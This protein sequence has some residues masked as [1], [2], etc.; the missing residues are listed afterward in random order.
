M[1]VCLRPPIGASG[2]VA[3][4]T[5]I[6]PKVMMDLLRHQSH[7]TFDTLVRRK[8]QMKASHQ[9]CTCGGLQGMQIILVFAHAHALLLNVYS[10][11]YDIASLFRVSVLKLFCD[12]SMR[13]KAWRS[14]KRGVQAT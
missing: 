14:R 13:E 8:Q 7:I 2:E 11:E 1:V 9:C 6:V 4:E 10:S 5:A 12:Q 3:D